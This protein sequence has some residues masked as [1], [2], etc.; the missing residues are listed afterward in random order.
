MTRCQTKCKLGR[1]ILSEVLLFKLTA[2]KKLVSKN[3]DYRSRSEKTRN[4]I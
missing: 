3:K 4:E 2:T 1:E